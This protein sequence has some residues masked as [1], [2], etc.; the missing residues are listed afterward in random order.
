MKLTKEHI[1]IK[2]TCP[3]LGN[4]YFVPERFAHDGDGLEV[5][6]G[7][8]ADWWYTGS[9]SWELYKEPKEEEPIVLEPG[10]PFFLT[11]SHIGVRVCLPQWEEGSYFVPNDSQDPYSDTTVNGIGY[12][13]S[14]K[15]EQE[16]WFNDQEWYLYRE[17]EAKSEDLSLREAMGSGKDF[18]PI[19]DKSWCYVNSHGTVVI[20][21]E[22]GNINAPLN[23]NMVNAR[24]ELDKAWLKWWDAAG[25]G[26]WLPLLKRELG[27]EE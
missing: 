9:E 11:E 26:G 15:V 14:G 17:P 13:K 7:A 24:Y 27:L 23:L 25:E 22:S 20:R 6:H 8:T 4:A 10:E 19:G 3:N 2:V 12:H 21:H 1:G 5:I 18:R 16:S